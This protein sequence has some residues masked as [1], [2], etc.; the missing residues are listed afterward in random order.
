MPGLHSRI[1]ATFFDQASLCMQ[2]VHSSRMLTMCSGLH[3][4]SASIGSCE[5]GFTQ[6]RH[7]STCTYKYTQSGLHGISV[8]LDSFIPGGFTQ[9]LY[10][11]QYFY[12]L[13]WSG[14]QKAKATSQAAVCIK[15]GQQTCLHILDDK[16]KTVLTFTSGFGWLS[17]ACT[18]SCR[19][20][21]INKLSPAYS[22]HLC[23]V[24]FALAKRKRSQQSPHLERFYLDTGANEHVTPSSGTAQ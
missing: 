17:T 5:P 11:D 14:L 6:T 18:L 1:T 23:G 8:S 3:S 22:A 20:Q 16:Q 10:T 15:T 19:N 7:T 24:V 2:N 13:S 4:N 21:F 12:Q 9:T